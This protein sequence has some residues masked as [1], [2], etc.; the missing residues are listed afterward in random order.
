MPPRVTML[1]QDGALVRV[2]GP[3]P[4]AV[5]R[6]EAGHLAPL[7][8]VIVRGVLAAADVVAKDVD[9][10]GRSSDRRRRRRPRRGL[11]RSSRRRGS[12]TSRGWC[13]ALERLMA[14]A[15]V[16]LD[17]RRPGR[18]GHRRARAARPAAAAPARAARTRGAAGDPPRPAA[19][20]DATHAAPSSRT[21]GGACIAAAP[22]GSTDARGRSAA[23]GGTCAP[24]LPAFAPPRDRV[25]AG[26]ATSRTRATSDA[27]R[28]AGADLAPSCRR[29]PASR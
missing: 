24:P 5:R 1:L 6:L 23:A 12:P 8:H 27:G 14:D 20:A 17:E 18:R 9:S 4:G 16:D 3:V 7:P 13:P 2:G 15:R 19:P 11:S 21:S 25:I 26:R 10:R 29:C 28:A 22:A